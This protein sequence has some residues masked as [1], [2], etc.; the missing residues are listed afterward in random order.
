MP[1]ASAPKAPWVQ[2]WL[3]PQTM[4]IPGWVIPSS[5][6]MTCTMPWSGESMSNNGT[7]NSLQFFCSASICRAAIGSVMGMPRGS[8]GML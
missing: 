3:S 1:K 5:G 8:V 2:V 6:P 4:V 7:P